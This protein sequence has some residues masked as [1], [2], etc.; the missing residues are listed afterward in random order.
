MSTKRDAWAGATPS[1][2]ASPRSASGGQPKMLIMDF[3]GAYLRPLGGWCPIAKIVQL[4]SEL[5]VDETATR[6][7]LARMRDKD[8]LEPEVR[9]GVRGLR[10]SARALPLL[11][12]S[13]QRIF[14]PHLPARLADG[15]V[16]VSFSI[17]EEERAKRHRLRSRL[18]WLGFGNL[19]NGLWMAPRRMARDLEKAVEELGFQHYVMTFEAA[20][21]GFEEL[22]A[23][24][25]RAWNLEEL[26]GLYTDFL[27]WARPV[28]DRWEGRFPEGRQAFADYT[29]SLYHWRKFPYLDPGLPEE[30]LPADWPGRAA[31]E[32]FAELRMRLEG[33]AIDYVRAF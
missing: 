27:A 8:L 3:C 28:L 17:P 25:R 1:M 12:E 9:Q 32:L 31:A 18:S 16:L 30:L 14:G 15:W 21:T 4:M 19:S 29:L 22:S 5:G 23:V 6:S 26:A 20:Y 7:A 11:A 33:P 24:V 10:L 2:A 13:D